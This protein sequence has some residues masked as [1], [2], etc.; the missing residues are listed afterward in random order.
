MNVFS[1][2]LTVN[3][4]IL[5]A[6]GA[7]QRF[8]VFS[9]LMKCF[10]SY[11]MVASLAARIPIGWPENVRG[12]FRWF[13]AISSS[14][15]AFSVDCSVNDPLLSR[16]YSKSLTLLIA[17]FVVPT[18]VP[19][20]FWFALFRLKSARYLVE[21]SLLALNRRAGGRLRELA[22]ELLLPRRARD[23][24]ERREN[25]PYP[26]LLGLHNQSRSLVRI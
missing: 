22:V 21:D 8:P 16:L 6:T 10:F 9:P 24:P 20:I 18:V 26:R 11:V 13:S 12:L 17:I 5:H 25:S 14:Q 23:A 15:E 19:A 7:L 1:L 2:I 3:A 4:T